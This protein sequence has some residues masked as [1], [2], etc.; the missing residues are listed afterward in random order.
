M[1]PSEKDLQR[2]ATRLVRAFLDGQLLM[3]KEPP[4]ALEK[5]LIDA[6]RKN[7]RDEL[8]IDREADRILEENRRQMTGMDQRALRMKI[9]EKVARDRGFVL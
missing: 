5:R 1:P 7:F 2:A 6:L 8:D 4:A 3:S 9:K